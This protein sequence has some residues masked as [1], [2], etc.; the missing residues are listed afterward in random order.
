MST[1]TPDS[2]KALYLIAWRYIIGDFYKVEF[3]NYA[4]HHIPVIERILNRFTVLVRGLE[5]PDRTST[6]RT[7][8]N[9]GYQRKAND[10]Q[11][12]STLFPIY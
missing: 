11:R 9:E 1:P 2:L 12:R 10:L 8:G 4:F 6:A 5:P 3:D 7:F